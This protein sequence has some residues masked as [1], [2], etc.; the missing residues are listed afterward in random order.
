M[1]AVSEKR[2]PAVIPAINCLNWPCVTK[3]LRQ[4]KKL[5]NPWVQFDISDGKFTA[6]KTWGNDLKDLQNLKKFL[7]NAGWKFNLES[8][9]MVENPEA[10]IEDWVKAGAKRIIVHLEAITD[11]KLQ[12]YPNLRMSRKV[13]SLIFKKCKANDVELGLA[14]NP[15]TPVEKIIPYLK[16]FKFIQI[17]AV[18]PGWASQKFQPK[19]LSKIQFLRK[20]FPSLVIEVDGGINLETARLAKRAGADILVSASYIWGSSNPKTTLEKLGKV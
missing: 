20:K 6:A 2:G 18:E 10:V 8:H 12:I 14:I 7:K 15:E 3:K 1:K 19:V 5:G 9:L 16:D 11:S 13:F 4:V 17:L